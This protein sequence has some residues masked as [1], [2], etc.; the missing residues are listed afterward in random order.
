[1]VASST[2]RFG[3]GGHHTGDMLDDQVVET[4]ERR[5]AELVDVEFGF[6]VELERVSVTL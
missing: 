2:G 6:V 5:V 1:M 4:R 3:L